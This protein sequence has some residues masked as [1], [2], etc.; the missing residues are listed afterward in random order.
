MTIPLGHQSALMMN[1]GSEGVN[2]GSESESGRPRNPRPAKR[3]NDRL[4]H[5]PDAILALRLVS[6]DFY[7]IFELPFIVEP[8][9]R[10]RFKAALR[11]DNISWYSRW[12]RYKGLPN[13][14]SA[15]CS[16]CGSRHSKSQFL[17]QELARNPEDRIC[18]GAK[19]TLSMGDGSTATLNE[20]LDRGSPLEHLG[21]ALQQVPPLPSL[22]SS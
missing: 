6:R 10:N 5:Y 1:K 3:I 20:I 16:A 15:T 18:I 8:L 22:T 12:E 21:T 19:E 11:R 2:T 4:S 9:F 7:R 14:P 13:L 17:P